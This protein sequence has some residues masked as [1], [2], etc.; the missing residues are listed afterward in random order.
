MRRFHKMHGLG[1]DFVV[2]DARGDGAGFAFDAA[3]A[4]AVA[5]RR[6]GV[7]CDQL[8]VLAASA[9]A[10]VAMRIWN[11]D[12]SEVAACGNATRC[13]AAL[14]G[15]DCAI[16]TPAGVL[17]ARLADGGVAV[18]MGPPRF[19]WEAIPL[20]YAMD[21]GAMPVG[22]GPL[23]EPFA[24]N[25]GNPHLVFFVDDPEAVPLAA[26]GPEIE[27]DPLF[28]ERTNLHVARIADRT[29]IHA[30]SW[31]RGAGLTRAC[32]TGACAVAVAA[33]SRRL[34]DHMVTVHLPGGPLTIDWRPGG[35]ITMTGPATHVFSGE[36]PDALLAAA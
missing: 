30:R 5:D 8:I 25:I 14:L 24:V 16:A 18:D 12:G 23:A 27:A 3:G 15:R 21:T 32:G 7:G 33:V 29:T 6:T 28:P 1:N 11:G 19:G 35:R 10:D 34:T 4:R 17:H 20:A 36:L 22:W 26:L 9:E 13:V 2:V 31:E